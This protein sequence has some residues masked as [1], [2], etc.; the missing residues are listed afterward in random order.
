MQRLLD[1]DGKHFGAKSH[2]LGL[3]NQ[4]V[5]LRD[6]LGAHDNVAI[7]GVDLGIEVSVSDQLDNPSFSILIGQVKLFGNHAVWGEKGISVKNGCWS[8]ELS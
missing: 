3:F 8:K 6:S 4:L 2:R 7:L 5:V 1:V